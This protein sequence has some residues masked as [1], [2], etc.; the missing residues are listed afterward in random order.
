MNIR[1]ISLAGLTLC[2][3]CTGS[4]NGSNKSGP[5][6]QIA[7]TSAQDGHVGMY[8]KT[9]QEHVMSWEGP[10]TSVSPEDDA[11]I[12]FDRIFAG[13][14]SGAS[15]AE[16][17]R[18]SAMQKSVLDH[19]IDDAKSISSQLSA[20]DK[21]K[22]DAYFTSLRSIEQRVNQTKALSCNAPS[23]SDYTTSDSIATKHTNLLDLMALAIKCDATRVITFFWQ[24]SNDSYP[25]LG[26]SGRGHHDISHADDDGSADARRDYEK[27]SIWHVQQ[28]AYFVK[29]LNAIDEGGSTALDNSIVQ[30]SSEMA[31]HHDYGDLPIL[32]VGKAGGKINSGRYVRIRDNLKDWQYGTNG[33]LANL[34][35]T[36]FKLFG[37]S[38]T[39]YARDGKKVLTELLTGA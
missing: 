10:N 13:Y 6:N 30:M 18:R 24:G 35:V 12:L 38:Q 37:M 15:D 11:G 34:Y 31:D 23:K 22:V 16:A 19:V 5:S 7:P 8:D 25:W 20:E 29:Q 17:K 36:Y 21:I 32:L 4:L 26:I 9:A 28:F 27:I 2:L 1:I 39:N 33:P 3:G 14:D